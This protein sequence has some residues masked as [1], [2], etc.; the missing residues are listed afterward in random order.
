[1]VFVVYDP[2]RPGLPFLA[3]LIDD[4]GIVTAGGFATFDEA[5]TYVTQKGAEMSQKLSSDEDA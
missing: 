4:D 1:M 5:Q 3:V 2:P